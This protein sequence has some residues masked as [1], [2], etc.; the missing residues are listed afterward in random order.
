MATNRNIPRNAPNKRQVAQQEDTPFFSPKL[1]KA[2]LKA[3]KEEL[4]KDPGFVLDFLENLPMHYRLWTKHDT[5]NGSCAVYVAVN[6]AD[7][8]E[9]IGIVCQRASSY[10]RCIAAIAYLFKSLTVESMFPDEDSTFH[11]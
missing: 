6:H 2:D 8:G 7:S 1:P 9:T 3:L 5:A 4:E 10:Y 11:W